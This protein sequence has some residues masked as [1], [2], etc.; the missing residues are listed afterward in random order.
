MIGSNYQHLPT[1]FEKHFLLDEINPYALVL[2]SS[3][4]LNWWGTDFD[5][6]NFKNFKL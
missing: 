3:W 1:L 4:H 5:P 6:L 2:N